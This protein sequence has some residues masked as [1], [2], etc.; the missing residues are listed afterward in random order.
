MLVLNG[1]GRGSH[2][3]QP[4][5]CQDLADVAHKLRSV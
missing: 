4:E 2:A 5:R 1:K 3:V